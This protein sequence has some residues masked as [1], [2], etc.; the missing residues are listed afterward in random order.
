M[1]TTQAQL[2]A[3]SAIIANPSAISKSSKV[4]KQ[5]INALLAPA[6]SLAEVLTLISEAVPQ[7]EPVAELFR[8]RDALLPYTSR[9]FRAIYIGHRV[10]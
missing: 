7:T 6:K 5:V 4:T 2:D 1:Q 10:Y 9:V 3:A 8:V